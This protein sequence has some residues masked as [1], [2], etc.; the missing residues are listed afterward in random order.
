MEKLIAVANRLSSEPQYREK[1][2]KKGRD[3]MQEHFSLGTV[4][5]LYEQAF[6]RALA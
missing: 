2:G 1:I 5:N 6:E 3:Y 4:V